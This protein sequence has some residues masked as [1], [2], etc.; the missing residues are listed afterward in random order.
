MP[1]LLAWT[2][3]SSRGMRRNCAAQPSIEQPIRTQLRL[4]S[5]TWSGVIP[6]ALQ[7]VSLWTWRILASLYVVAG[8][9]GL[10]GAVGHHGPAEQLRSGAV[11]VG[12]DAVN[13][14]AKLGQRGGEASI[15]VRANSSGR[16]VWVAPDS[17]PAPP[18]PIDGGCLDAWRVRPALQDWDCLNRMAFTEL[19][20][21]Q[22]AP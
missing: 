14:S 22:S 11:V 13:G 12:S 19:R 3:L 4:H 10:A 20:P 9:I 2:R 16:P 21:L 5:F 8:G 6:K 1:P 17:E 7:S 15:S 18:S